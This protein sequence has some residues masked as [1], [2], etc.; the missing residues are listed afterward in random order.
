MSV[1]TGDSME[2]IEERFAGQGYGVFKDAVAEAVIAT[3]D[4]IRRRY[5]ELRQDAAELQRL[6]RMGAETAAAKAEPTL[7]KMYDAMGLI[8]R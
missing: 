3:I 2:A 4:P 7:H 1:A 5:E 8:A 6:L